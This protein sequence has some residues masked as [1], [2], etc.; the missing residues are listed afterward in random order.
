[1][2]DMTPIADGAATRL[3]FSLMRSA[4][5]DLAHMLRSIEEG[6]ALEVLE[7]VEYRTNY[8]LGSS[9]E[10]N[11]DRAPRQTAIRML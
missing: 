11:S 8:R 1:M 2:T 9:G 3:A 7:A 6:A 4:Y 10:D 5:I